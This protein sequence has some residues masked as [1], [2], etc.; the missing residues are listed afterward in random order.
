MDLTEIVHLRAYSETYRDGAVT[1]FYQLELPDR[2]NGL[3][4]MVLLKEISVASDLCIFIHWHGQV[5]RKD[6][7][8]LGLQLASAFSEFG[9]IDHSVWVH[10]YRVPQK[11]RR[12]RHEEKS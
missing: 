3:V 1:A 2:A 10:E 7:S 12:I 8:P 4:D 11:A 5:S 6:K 9:R